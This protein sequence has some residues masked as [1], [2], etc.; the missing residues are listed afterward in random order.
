MRKFAFTKTR[1]RKT[2]Q[3]TDL[4]NVRIYTQVAT[5]DSRSCSL[6]VQKSTVNEAIF[7]DRSWSVHGLMLSRHPR[8]VGLARSLTSPVRLQ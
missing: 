3:V 5:A 4:T 7:R 1:R 2:L 8:L 6:S